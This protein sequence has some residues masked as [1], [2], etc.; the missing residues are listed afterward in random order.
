MC[1]KVVELINQYEEKG[2]FT[3]AVVNDVIIAEAEKV[4]NVNIPEQYQWF[5]KRY[6][7][8][9][10]G[11]IETLGVGK[12][13]KI[14]FVNKTLEFREYGLPNEMIVIENCDEWIYCID[15]KNGN[16]DMWSLGE[17]KCSLAYKDFFEYLIDRMN[18]AI[19]NM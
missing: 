7:H 1:D 18:D 6:G 11:G 17:K 12:N 2:D 9:G 16:I 8:G 10:I 5:L 15:T 4:L 14:I 3:Y 19:E 13:G